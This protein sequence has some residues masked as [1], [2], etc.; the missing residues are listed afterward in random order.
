MF[1]GELEERE[2]CCRLKRDTIIE[3]LLMNQVENRIEVSYGE[4]REEKIMSFNFCKV[5]ERY[6]NIL[7]KISSRV[8]D[9]FELI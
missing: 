1:V 7:F 3:I 9:G 4:L 6:Y 2:W 8:V 5:G